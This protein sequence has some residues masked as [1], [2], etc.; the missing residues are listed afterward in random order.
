MKLDVETQDGAP[1]PDRQIVRAALRE[2]RMELRRLYGSNAPAAF[3]YGSYARGEEKATSD[4]DVLLLYAQ[5]IQ[6]GEEIERISAILAK[7]NLRYQVLISILP[8]RHSTYRTS[9]EALWQNIRREAALL[10]QI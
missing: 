4:V 2:L 8:T 9:S 3:V 5:E 7:L 10:E 1:Q 6:P